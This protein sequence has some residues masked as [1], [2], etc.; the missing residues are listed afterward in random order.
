MAKIKFL[1]DSAADIPQHY[2]DELGIEVIHFPIILGDREIHDGVDYTNQEFYDVLN[3]VDKIPTHAQVTAY[4]FEEI[5]SNIF[6]AGYDAVIYT[7]INFKGTATGS[8]AL[9]AKKTF[10]ADHPEAAGKFQIEVLDSKNY[11]YSYGY[12]VVEAARKAQSGNMTCDEVVEMIEDWLTHAKILFAPYDLKFARK[13]G[14]VSAAAAIMGTAMGIR[15]IMSFPN[16]DSKVLAKPRGD[17]NVVPTIVKMMKE[18]MEPGSPYIVIHAALPER[19]REISEACIEA[20]GYAPAEEF[21]IGGVIS[22]NA[23]PN[24]VGVIFRAK[25]PIF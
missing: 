16:G 17:K 1:T 24:L 20:V 4:E 14:R 21:L 9:Q 19:N 12:A 18:E 7:A 15:P 23:G 13:S 25:D 2:V 11:T 8:N 5:F 10:F 3:S 6:A 22:I